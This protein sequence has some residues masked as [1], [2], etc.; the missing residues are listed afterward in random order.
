MQCS[1]LKISSNKF[2]FSY[3]LKLMFLM[4]NIFQ[5]QR[6]LLKVTSSFILE[7]PYANLQDWD[8]GD[9]SGYKGHNVALIDE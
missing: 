5:C 3:A 8:G 9:K 4:F 6:F 7:Y 1:C 2:D